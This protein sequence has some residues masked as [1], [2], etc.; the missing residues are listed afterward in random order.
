[1]QMRKCIS[2][3]AALAIGTVHVSTAR[4]QSAEEFYKNNAIKLIVGNG[5]GGDYDATARMV[6]RYLPKHI[7]G[8]PNIIVQNMPGANGVTAAN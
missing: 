3:L 8:K 6:A 5:A 4:A 2:V 7:P 1:M